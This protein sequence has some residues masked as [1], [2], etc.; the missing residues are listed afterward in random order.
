MKK[1]LIAAAIL[2]VVPVAAN[3]KSTFYSCGGKQIRLFDLYGDDPPAS[4]TIN[5]EVPGE[6]HRPVFKFDLEKHTATLNKWSCDQIAK[7]E[8]D[9]IGEDDK[10]LKCTTEKEILTCREEKNK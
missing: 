1:F 4:A 9:G 3:A 8:Y 7:Q 2:C 6:V 5:L 10:I